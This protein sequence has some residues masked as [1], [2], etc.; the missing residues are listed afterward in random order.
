MRSF[1]RI[2]SSSILLDQARAPHDAA[3]RF[4]PDDE[5][6]VAWL[7]LVERVDSYLAVQRPHRHRDRTRDPR[8]VVNHRV[9]LERASGLGLILERGFLIDERPRMR[10]APGPCRRRGFLF[11]SG[12]NDSPP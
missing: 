1:I 8:R 7:P 5:L 9:L 10:R 12:R 3:D 4:A 6:H 11:R 2:S